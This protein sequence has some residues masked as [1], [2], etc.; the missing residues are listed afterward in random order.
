MNPL[1]LHSAPRRALAVPGV[2]CDPG[3]AALLCGR[4]RGR[5]AR[6]PGRPAQVCLLLAVC[7]HQLT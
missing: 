6:P 4:P 2:H 7:L 5:P 1:L 3:A